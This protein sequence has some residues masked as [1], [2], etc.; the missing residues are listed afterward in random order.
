MRRL[1]A[2]FLFIA[3]L[4]ISCD[5]KKVERVSIDYDSLY[6]ESLTKLTDV[7]VHDIFS[8]PVASRI[9]A[10]TNITGYEIMAV[11]NDEYVSLSGQLTDFKS[12]EPAA[13]TSLNYELSAIYGA[14]NTGRALIFSED[15]IS[16]YVNDLD[17]V[18]I[19][20]GIPQTEI[21]NAKEYAAMASAE[22]LKWA[23][24]DNYKQTRSFEKYAIMEG[25]AYWK[26]TPPAYMEGIEPHWDKIRPFVIDSASQFKPIPP[27]PFSTDKESKF[28]SEMME[29]YNVGVNLTKEQEAIAKFWDC[30]PY[31]AHQQGH[32]MFATKKITPGGHWIEIVRLVTDKADND[33]SETIEAYTWV[34]VALADGF[35]S[36]W[37]EKYRSS[38]VRPETIINQIVDEE[39]VP[40]LQTPPFPEYTSGHSVISRSA[41]TVLTYLYGEEFSFYDDT[42]ERYGLPA[43]NFNSFMEASEEA[44]VSRLY[45]GIHYRPA[46]EEGVKQGERVGRYIIENLKTKEATEQMA[47]QG[48]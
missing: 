8:P 4:G 23:D 47:L 1:I 39:W 15:M 24:K 27:T 37:D 21:D 32:M 13:D 48:E 36:C 11:N 26:P 40:L 31:V 43:R 14:L 19:A 42:E 30:N 41:A 9:Y 16:D 22:V 2:G 10:Y 44:A 29:V 20:S 7:I 6:R 12:F 3:A 18:F 28:Y 25:D 45:G 46:I 17:S 34:S 33:F 5:T 35:I 38:L